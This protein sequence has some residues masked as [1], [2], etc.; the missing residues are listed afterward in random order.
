MKQFTYEVKDTYDFTIFLDKLREDSTYINASSVLVTILTKRRDPDYFAYLKILICEA[1]S[2]ATIVGITTVDYLADGPGYKETEVGFTIFEKSSLK[3]YSFCL[4]NPDLLEIGQSLTEKAKSIDNLRGIE[5]FANTSKVD[6][7]PLFKIIQTEYPDIPIFGGG[8]GG[9]PSR[10]TTLEP[11][12]YSDRAYYN[13]IIF[14]LFSGKEL[15]IVSEYSLGWNAIG[16]KMHITKMNGLNEI[17]EI[18]QKKA[19]SIYERYLGVCEKE[20]FIENTAEFPLIFQ[21]GCFTVARVPVGM[22]S[23]GG[24]VFSTTLQEGDVISFSYGDKDTILNEAYLISEFFHHQKVEGTMLFACHNRKLYLQD[25]ENQEIDIFGTAD[26]TPLVFRAFS[27]ILMKNKNGGVMT[28]AL[29][30]VGFIEGQD[31]SDISLTKEWENRFYDEKSTNPL[32]SDADSCLLIN[33]KSGQIP[34]QDRVVSFLK[35]ITDDLETANVKLDN[36]ASFDV[37]TKIYN[38]RKLLEVITDDLDTNVNYPF[39][40]IM[41]D[42]DNFKKINDTYGHD[43]GDIVLERV[44]Q[45]AKNTIRPTDDIGRWGGEEFVVFLRRASFD[46]AIEVAERIRKA[47]NLLQWEDMNPIS[48]SLGVVEAED[49]VPFNRLYEK[50]DKRLYK[51]KQTGKNKVVFED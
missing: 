22:G 43:V 30:A 38:R 51:A 32:Y 25:Q 4:E 2:K 31:S 48:I 35:A 33:H 13:G 26:D 12:I 21:K 9:L 29:V 36:L 49:G 50:V 39:A 11:F 37:L 40:F 41:F 17:I 23:D 18:D 27:E 24:V 16:K 28:S 42:I 15:S 45:T 34:F 5:V 1:L 7:D 14:V 8:V 20:H 47:I 46:T 10:K 6:L 3:L 19:C 44:A